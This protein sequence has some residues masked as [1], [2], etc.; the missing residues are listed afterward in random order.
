MAFFAFAARRCP[1]NLQVVAIQ[2]RSHGRF[3]QLDIQ[4]L[5]RIKPFLTKRR[6]V[7]P[8]DVAF[9]RRVWYA[10]YSAP[11]NAD[12][13]PLFKPLALLPRAPRPAATS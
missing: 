2:I 3:A 11:D 13:A 12:Y 1:E 6:P 5:M 9:L 8:V 10:L 4:T 7:R